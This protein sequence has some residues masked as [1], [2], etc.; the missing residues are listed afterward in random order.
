MKKCNR[1]A[2]GLLITAAGWARQEGARGRGWGVFRV[3][4]AEERNWSGTAPLQ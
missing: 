4:G 2:L 1:K 3:A